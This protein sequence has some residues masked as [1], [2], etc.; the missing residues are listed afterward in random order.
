MK[1]KSELRV[2]IIGGGIGGAAT[3]VALQRKA[4]VQKF[5]SKPQL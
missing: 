3:A 4:F 5:M 2:A 1:S